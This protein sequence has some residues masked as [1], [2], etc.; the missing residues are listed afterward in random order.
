ML[1][2]FRSYQKALEL[3]KNS[4]AHKLPR[5]LKD[6]FERAASSIVLN[7][8]EGSGRATKKDRM[9]FYVMAFASLRE[10]Q[11]IIDLEDSLVDLKAPADE[12]GAHLYKL[13]H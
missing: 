13:T 12:L 4:R 7:L 1:D 9:R 6:Q 8:A 5:F 11:A 2:N 3:Y 10:V